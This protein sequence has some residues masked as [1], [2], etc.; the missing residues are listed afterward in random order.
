MSSSSAD[1][2]IKSGSVALEYDDTVYVKNSIDPHVHS[3]HDKKVIQIII[4]GPAL[5]YDTGVHA[6]GLPCSIRIVCR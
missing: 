1:I 6:E 4:S 5:D 3:S 2:N